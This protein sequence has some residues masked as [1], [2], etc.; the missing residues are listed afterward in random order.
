MFK[1]PFVSPQ[2]L[3]GRLADPNVAIV[4]ASWYLPGS[5]RDA[6]I[7]HLAGHI[8]GAVF[9]DIDAIADTDT[10]LPHM[11]P[12]PADFG[13]M[14]STLGIA[15]EQTIVVYDEPGLFSAPRVW[16]TFRIMGAD[17]VR[18]LQGGGA[19]WRAE[20]LPV[21]AGEVTRPRAKFASRFDPAQVADLA[22]MR[23]ALAEG[24]AIVVDARPAARFTGEAPEPRPGL[25]PGHMPG[26]LNVPL[27][28]VVEN[29][30]LKSPE[31]L[32]RLFAETGIDLQKPIITTC[33]SGVTSAALA[34]ALREAGA[35]DVAV[36]D[37]SWAEW[38]A[39]EDTEVA[40][41]A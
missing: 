9:F 19:R 37:G 20:G 7:E 27:G 8:P 31:A 29:G 26:A 36:Y 1:S 13:R 11:L 41:G 22:R 18:I 21:E 28:A 25:K 12:A 34:L 2:W 14:M 15:D 4:D 16:W 24:E 35:A 39:R 40:V 38:G 6:R 10:D 3:A 30:T 5:G 32:R 23:K 33:G 17:D